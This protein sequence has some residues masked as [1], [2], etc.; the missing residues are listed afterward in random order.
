M[1]KRNWKR[2]HRKFYFN[3]YYDQFDILPRITIEHNKYGHYKWAFV[4]GWL[5]WNIYFNG[6]PEKI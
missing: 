5:F 1:E 4:V 3:S 6:E 2:W